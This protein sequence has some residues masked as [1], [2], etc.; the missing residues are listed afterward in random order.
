MFIN[1]KKAGNEASISKEA[2]TKRL[3]LIRIEL[4]F[5]KF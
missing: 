5:K 3:L 2:E 4:I 1:S